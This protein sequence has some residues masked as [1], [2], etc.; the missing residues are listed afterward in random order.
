MNHST[1]RRSLALLLVFCAAALSHAA[2]LVAAVRAADDERVAAIL[3]ADPKRL[4]AIFSNDLH[5]AHSNGKIDTKKSYLE[6]LVSKSTVYSSYEY[7]QR[8]FFVASPDVVLMTAHILLK[9]GAPDKQTPNDLNVL[10]VFRNEGGHW[11]FLA[12]QS[13]KNP[14]PAAP[15]VK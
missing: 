5:Y 11:R 4:D 10:A 14:P 13:C 1:L 8:D 15:L 7:V 12:W 6:S 2:D 3:A 9:A